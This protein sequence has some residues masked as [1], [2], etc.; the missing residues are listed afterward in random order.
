MVVI[1]WVFMKSSKLHLHGE[2]SASYIYGARFCD[3]IKL[4]YLLAE[5][6]NVLEIGAANLFPLAGKVTLL[7]LGPALAWRAVPC[8]RPKKKSFCG[9]SQE[10][11]RITSQRP[12][13]SPLKPSTEPGEA[14]PESAFC[15]HL[16]SSLVPRGGAAM[17]NCDGN[18]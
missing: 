14:V 1:L 16:C 7:D 17:C 11:G 12:F 3:I 9:A 18:V 4:P 10:D 5:K 6:C 2:K 15:N 8:W 13:Q